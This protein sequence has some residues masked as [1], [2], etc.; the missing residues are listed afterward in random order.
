MPESKANL[1][2]P[3]SAP[4][5]GG[6]CQVCCA[7]DEEFVRN[8][9]LQKLVCILLWR[10]TVNPHVMLEFLHATSMLMGSFPK[11]PISNFHFQLVGH[12]IGTLAVMEPPSTFS[13]WYPGGGGLQW[14]FTGLMRHILKR[15]MDICISIV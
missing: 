11:S 15:F 7:W 6:Q 4:S 1:C 5:V 9:F 13:L 12:P 2:Y 10:V 3:K 8:L 14:P